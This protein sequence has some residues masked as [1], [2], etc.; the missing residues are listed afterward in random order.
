MTPS[1]FRQVCY[2][3]GLLGSMVQGDNYHLVSALYSKTE[4]KNQ[5][6]Q[7]C[8]LT[9]Q[10]VPYLNELQ[11]ALD[12]AEGWIV[13]GLYHHIRVNFSKTAEE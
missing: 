1:V 13:D 11:D 3:A 10:T 6:I 2:Q 9:N 4:M 8:L 12:E 7:A 5:L